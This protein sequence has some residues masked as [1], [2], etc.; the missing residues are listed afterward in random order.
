MVVISFLS[1]FQIGDICCLKL[2]KHWSSGD[3]KKLNILYLGKI[4][5]VQTMRVVDKNTFPSEGTE[6]ELEA[7]RLQGASI[8]SDWHSLLLYVNK[9][10]FFL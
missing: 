6:M 2:S 9:K 3:Q 1:D 8:T 4:L 7:D 10:D 5:T